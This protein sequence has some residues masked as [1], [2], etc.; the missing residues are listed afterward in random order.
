MLIRWRHLSF[1]KRR[2]PRVTIRL[3]A[4]RNGNDDSENAVF[5]I[6][7]DGTF[8]PVSRI[9]QGTQLLSGSASQYSDVVES[10]MQD[11]SRAEEINKTEIPAGSALGP[12]ASDGT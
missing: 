12:V 6:C 1:S 3:I 11:A 8:A 7:S 5:Y 4:A 10:A 2:K 9:T